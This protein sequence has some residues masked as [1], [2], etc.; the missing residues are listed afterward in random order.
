MALTL[1]ALVPGLVLRTAFGAEYEDADGVLF[2]LGAA[3][4]L[5]AVTYL[6]A[7]FLLGLRRRA[8][9]AVLAVAAVAE[10]LLLL[11][12]SDLGDFAAIVLA[13]QAAAAIAIM[14]LAARRPGQ[15][16]GR[17]RPSQASASHAASESANP[18]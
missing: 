15:G 9:A 12:A 11:G 7:Q 3:Y 2:A 13:V 17:R 10:P 18:A 14:A 8:F 4:A 16:P 1:Y 6:G 5:L